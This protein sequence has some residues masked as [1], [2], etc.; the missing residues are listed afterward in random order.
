MRLP[1]FFRGGLAVLGATAVVLLALVMILAPQLFTRRDPNAIPYLERL[2]PPPP[3]RRR[4]VD[5]PLPRHRLAG[6]AW[7]RRLRP[8]DRRGADASDRVLPGLPAD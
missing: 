1:R 5:R 8:A 4:H 6:G 2:H 3:G 7:H